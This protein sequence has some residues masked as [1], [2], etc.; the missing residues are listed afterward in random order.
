M[1]KYLMRP[2]VFQPSIL[3]QFEATYPSKFG[4]GK[5]SPKSSESSKQTAADV[6]SILG[7]QKLLPYPIAMS[8]SQK[9]NVWYTYPH[10]G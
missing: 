10:F 5:T 3:T 9:L 6:W 7:L 4:I 2:R 8:L 1:N